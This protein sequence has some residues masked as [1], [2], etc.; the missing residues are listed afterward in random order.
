MTAKILKIA[1]LITTFVAIVGTSA[2]VTLTLL[3]QSEDTVVIPDLVHKE[4]IEVLGLLTEL[5]LNTKIKGSDFSSNVPK[6]HV[7]SQEP[8]AGSEIKKGRD[9][10][11]VISKGARS[12][13]LPNIA[14]LTIRQARMILD[15]N[16]FRV[17]VTSFAHHDGVEKDHVI[18]QSPSPGIMATQGKQ[19]DLLVSLGKRPTTFMMPD[20]TG[21]PLDDA[22]G[23]IE[24]ADL[25]IGEITSLYRRNRRR[26][27][28]VLQTPL[29]GYPVSSEQFVQLAF[30]R[31]PGAT[32]KSSST[33]MQGV[34]L[35]RYRLENGFLKRY[36]RA[37]V[38][39]FG[40]SITLYDELMK[41]GEEVWIMVPKDHKAEI[42]LY[43]DEE[44]VTEETFDP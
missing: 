14:G 26:H 8:V 18:V 25:A 30:N 28:I 40:T 5:G 43:E 36:I 4:A 11:I 33:S 17:G 12:I 38:D 32:D 2:Y 37:Q 23:L 9:I 44:L 1:A 34:R 31:K 20:L 22:V 15:E 24:A 39:I 29:S 42:R 27:T 10:R 13:M 35:F 21:H 6:N 19:I 7:M 3:I 16:D 41:P